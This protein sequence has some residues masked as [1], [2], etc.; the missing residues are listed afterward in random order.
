[1]NDGCDTETRQ[2][3]ENFWIHQL[4]TM[5]PFGLN[6][7]VTGM[8]G[9]ASD[10]TMDKKENVKHYFS[11]PLPNA[12]H[13]IRPDNPCTAKKP[14]DKNLDIE[15]KETTN[16]REMTQIYR[17]NKKSLA[18]PIHD[19][20]TKT[21]INKDLLLASHIL[22]TI[23]K[24]RN[25]NQQTVEKIPIYVK[26]DYLNPCLDKIGIRNMIHD[27][28]IARI[29]NLKDSD[30]K[31]VTVFNLVKNNFC[32][33][34]NYNNI[35]RELDFEK[36]TDILSTDC[37][38]HRPHTVTQTMVTFIAGASAAVS[39]PLN[40]TIVRILEV[41]KNNTVKYCDTIRERSGCNLYWSVNSS[42]QE[43]KEELEW[44]P[45]E[46]GNAVNIKLE[47]VIAKNKGLEKLMAINRVLIGEKQDDIG[48]N[49]DVIAAYKYAQIQSCDVERSFSIYKRIFE[50]RRTSLTEEN[51][52]KYIDDILSIGDEIQKHAKNIYGDVLEL[53]RTDSGKRTAFLDLDITSNENIKFKTYDKTRDF[54]FSVIKY[55]KFDSCVPQ[56]MIR[57]IMITEIIRYSFTNNTTQGLEYNINL[58][59]NTFKNNGS[60]E[61]FIT[62][63]MLQDM[64]TTA[65]NDHLANDEQEVTTAPENGNAE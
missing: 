48:M 61:D 55:P 63:S 41:V 45:G 12:K 40:I 53:N 54:S 3:A 59:I 30:Y 65:E 24:S 13:R 2:N 35:L 22:A 25:K 39:K 9:F 18:N 37:Q 10:M 47:Q 58:L 20:V 5:H 11:N 42:S 14:K 34:S 56:N 36:L 46:I 50:D 38:C 33:Y 64:S 52:K 15:V 62:N 16:A 19:L 31:I 8:K 26:V 29:L 51:I 57:N 32:R 23:K 6:D 7:K 4:V 27:S 43:V 1:M 21:V 49:P 44:I 28:T 60:P 17:N